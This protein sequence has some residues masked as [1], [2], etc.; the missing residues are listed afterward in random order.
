[1]RGDRWLRF[2]KGRLGR[3]V[4]SA[5]ALGLDEA[6]AGGPGYRPT[7][8]VIGMAADRL[9]RELPADLQTQFRELPSVIASLEADAEELRRRITALDSALSNVGSGR[10][11]TGP[12]DGNV[13][14]VLAGPRD[15]VSA[16]LREVVA[17][18]E[19]LRL[20]LIRMHAGLGSPALLTARLDDARALADDMGRLVEGAREADD[21]LG[22]PRPRDEVGTP[23]PV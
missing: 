2:W 4:F 8:V 9:F 13:H 6:P 18:L 12:G 21:I 1:M 5:A 19:S 3:G 16:R 14:G 23:T 15:A 17:A 7:A 22:I 20:Q 10:V 11:L